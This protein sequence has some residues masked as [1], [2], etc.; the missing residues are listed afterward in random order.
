MTKRVKCIS[1]HGGCHNGMLHDGTPVFALPSG[2]IP[3]VDPQRLRLEPN[4]GGWVHD[5]RIPG[6]YAAVGQV[7]EVD[8]DFYAD[9]A[10]WEDARPPA[11]HPRPAPAPAPPGGEK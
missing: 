10:N 7:Y 4:P 6:G 11:P 8:D 9:G 2:E 3:Q 1:P 5:G